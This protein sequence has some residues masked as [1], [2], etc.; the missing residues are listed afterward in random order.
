MSIHDKHNHWRRRRRFLGQPAVPTGDP[1]ERALRRRCA[2]Y[3]RRLVS[4]PVPLD[5]ELL[6]FA[7]ILL[8]PAVEPLN[9]VI[10]DHLE[11][12]DRRHYEQEFEECRYRPD[13][14]P[15]EAAEA[16]GHCDRR[17]ADEVLQ[18]LPELAAAQERE[19]AGGPRSDFEQR[20]AR[21][22]KMLALSEPERELAILLFV[23]GTFPPAEAYIVGH[24]QCQLY[25]NRRY[26]QALLGGIST[27][28]LAA[29]LEGTLR[30]LELIELERGFSLS[31]DFLN[32]FHQPTL[33]LATGGLFARLPRPSLALERHLVPD[34][35]VAH[36]ARLLAQRPE[37]P[38][39]VLLYG[40]PGTGKTSFA[41][42]LARHLRVP[43]YA[44]TADAEN[45]PAKRRAAIQACLNLT[46]QGEGSLV[47]VDE[48]DDLLNTQSMF[49]MMREPRSK[50]W[51]CELMEAP[52]A[53]MIWIVNSIEGIDESVR[54]RFAFSVPFLPLNRAQRVQVW[55]S[56][57]RANRVRRAFAPAEIARL[58]ARYPCA[59]GPVD[60][61]VKQA[62]A[63]APP[64]SPAFREA[65]R[66][67]LDAH[68][69][70]THGVPP[71]DA[72]TVEPNYTLDAL[73]LDTDLPALVAT[74]SAFSERLRAGGDAGPVRNLNL[75]FH[76]PPGTGKSE[77][78]RH[79]AERLG[80]ELHVK[81][82]AEL[83]NCYVGE[84]EKNI[85]LAF[86]QAEQA[87]AVLVIDEADTFLFPRAGA[88]HSWEI[89]F[90]NAFLTT[91]ERYRGIL[92]CTTNRLTG[93]D[94]ASI[95][96]FQVKAGFDW[97]TPDGAVLLFGRLLGPLAARA[98]DPAAEAA[99]RALRRLAPGD[100][101]VVRDRFALRPREDVTPGALVAALAE[102][103]RLKPGQ[104]ARRI[105]F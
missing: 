65:V 42:A 72:D 37:H 82:G 49:G 30:R 62:R 100:F 38:A 101:R 8:G 32:L 2:E 15:H 102:E 7:G 60:L 22:Q 45:N 16:L 89:S 25:A 10:L 56:V 44:V 73:N 54:R 94:E 34:G 24:L 84:T 74:A 87:G 90:T 41:R 80:R 52:G 12:P 9:A 55:E 36:L 69:R 83:L 11:E 4:V 95:R 13:V 35:T 76:G 53:R 20:A 79:L 97:L 77:L 98:L 68:H 92:V 70:L 29:T 26:L 23:A 5:R 81:Q 86:Y 50:A 39:H 75:L 43:A 59:A 93:L 3:L 19:L 18:L 40:A 14:W 66:A 67:A 71:A 27:P 28:A 17:A 47:V 61:A 63:A 78:A 51:L 31:R 96:R 64:G 33:N 88:R 103:T 6:E 46:S 21:F 91:M 99:L 48:A 105:G 58:A 104:E 57:L 1:N 85:R